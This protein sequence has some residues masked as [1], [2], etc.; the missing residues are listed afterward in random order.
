MVQKLLSA[1]TVCQ[2]LSAQIVCQCLLRKR[3]FTLTNVKSHHK[4]VL[5]DGSFYLLLFDQC[6][7]VFQQLPLNVMINLPQIFPS[8]PYL[9]L[10]C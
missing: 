1:Q 2:C 6:C 5:I 10:L 7:T 3:V 9:L 8:A 4:Y